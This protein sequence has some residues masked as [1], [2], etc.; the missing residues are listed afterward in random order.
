METHTR[1]FGL[2]PDFVESFRLL[3]EDRRIP[4]HGGIGSEENE[5]ATERRPGIA[6]RRMKPGRGEPVSQS[7]PVISIGR[8][9][10]QPLLRGVKRDWRFS[11]KIIRAS[12]ASNP[13][14]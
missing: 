9:S 12:S 11:W 1:V 5:R 2:E 6:A 13:T 14:S 10:S 3:L 4:G 8:K 7:A